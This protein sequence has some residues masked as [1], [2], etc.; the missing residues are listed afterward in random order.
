MD[1]YPEHLGIELDMGSISIPFMEWWSQTKTHFA[2]VP[3]NVA[4]QWL[5][6]HWNGSP[7]GYLRSANYDFELCDFASSRLAGV[8]SFQSFFAPNVADRIEAGGKW[9]ENAESWHWGMPRAMIDYRDFPTPIII[10]DNADD[11]LAREEAKARAEKIPAGLILIE[12]HKRLDIASYLISENRFRPIVK[13]W[14]MK[15][16]MSR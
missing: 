16:R 13:I 12:G 8:L 15:R 9:L 2:N 14:M 6:R 1:N 3:E 10:L 7:F 4:E 5:H 11:H